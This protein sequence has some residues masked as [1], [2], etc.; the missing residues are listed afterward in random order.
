MEKMQAQ[1]ERFG[2]EMVID[3]VESVD[4]SKAPFTVK[5]AGG[6]TEE[7]QT[8]IISTAPPPSGLDCR[9][10]KSFLGKGFPPA[11]SATE[12]FTREKKWRSWAEGTLR[13][14]NPSF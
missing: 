7:A 12:L 10:R 8:V 9:Q 2:T 11:R 6:K 5:T 14:K 13:W 4:F 3:Y 1:A